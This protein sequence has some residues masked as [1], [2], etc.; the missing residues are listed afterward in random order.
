MRDNDYPDFEAHKVQHEK[1]FEKVREV[2]SEYDHFVTFNGRPFDMRVLLMHGITHEIRPSVNIDSGRYNR[3]NHTDLRQI[4][5]GTDMYAPGKLDFFCKKFLGDQK[6]EDI[7]GKLVQSYFDLGL[8]EDIATYC[9][10]DCNLI[11]KLYQRVELAG[12][13]E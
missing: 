10:Q 3:G 7:D 2:L 4:L 5:A 13:L 9:E 6:T 12:L 11:F 1:M 8:H